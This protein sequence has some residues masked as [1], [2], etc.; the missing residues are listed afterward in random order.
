MISLSERFLVFVFVD[1]VVI[2][3]GAVTFSL[4]LKETNA[5]LRL[6]DDDDVVLLVDVAFFILSIYAI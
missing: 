4:L 2:V 6:K 3:A 1:V 5:P